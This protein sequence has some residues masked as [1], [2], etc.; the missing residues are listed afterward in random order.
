MIGLLL[1][2]YPAP[3]RRRYGEEFRAVLESRP[4]GP[5]DFADV[6]LGALDARLAPRRV[7]GSAGIDGGPRMMLRI[8]GYGAVAGGLLWFVGIFASSMSGGGGIWIP[9]IMLGTLGLL[10]ALIG[11][12]AFQAYRQPVL[13]WAAV[14]IPGLGAI[15]S[16]VGLVGMA[17]RPEDAFMIGSFSS[18]AIWAIGLVT[19]V[20]GSILFAVAT[21][22][23]KVFSHGAAI[24]MALSA[25]VVLLVGFG[26]LGGSTYG[27]VPSQ[28]V[29][30]LSL[31]SFAASWVALGI[32]A[33][34]RG[35]IRAIAP[36]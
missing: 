33:L 9:V 8:G 4:L 21:I 31:G 18:W 30:A 19:T 16:V 5:F 10:L 20:G 15:A 29:F 3:W 22:R 12:S 13:A 27:D 2:M 36:A 35:P 34:R 7:P 28:L 14:V 11:L 17:T 23:A 6:L 24:A 1:A 26:F 32:R 25:V